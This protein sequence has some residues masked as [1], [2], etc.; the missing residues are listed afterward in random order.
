MTT[1]AIARGVLACM[2]AG[3]ANVDEQL[4]HGVAEGLGM[5]VPPN[6]GPEYTRNFKQM[7]VR[8]SQQQRIPLVPF[9]LK[10]VAD[11]PDPT[12]LFQE[13]RIHPKA[14]AHP[15]ILGNVWSVLKKWL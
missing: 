13:D 9:L 15:I 7:F 10:G 8:L 6:Y 2:L 3:L 5:E 11:G 1:T 4:V 14:Q 12:A